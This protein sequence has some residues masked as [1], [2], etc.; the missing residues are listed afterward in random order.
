MMN[1]MTINRQ[2]RKIT[3]NDKNTNETGEWTNYE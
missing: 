2:E 3:E 1:K